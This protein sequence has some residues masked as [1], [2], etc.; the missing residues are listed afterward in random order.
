MK[1]HA[2]TFGADGSLIGIITEGETIPGDRTANKDTAALLFNAGLIH[3]IGPNRVYVKLARKLA[4]L[5]ITVLRFDFSGIGDS[6]PRKD[7]LP[8]GASILDEARQAMD[9]LSQRYGAERFICIGLCAGA[10][11]AAQISVN[12]GRVDK[13]ILINPLLPKTQQTDLMHY[14][15]Y[16]HSTALF[17]PRS[18][19]R[20][21]FLKS[22]YQTLWQVVCLRIRTKFRSNSLS[23]SELP[24]IINE[25]KGFFHK[26]KTRGIRLFLACS[27]DDIGDQYL[28][29]VIGPEYNALKRSGQMTTVSLIGADH[30]LT[31]LVCQQRLLDLVGVW[32]NGA[33]CPESIPTAGVLAV[34]LV[35]AYR[36]TPMEHAAQSAPVNL[37]N[38][39]WPR[40]VSDSMP[41]AIETRDLT[42]YY[43]VMSGWKKLLGKHDSG[44]CAVDHVNLRVGKNEL[45]GLV[46]PN[47]AGKTTLIKMLTTLVLPT[48]GSIQIAGY[49]IR[50]EE[51]VKKA[52]GL[53]TS[54]ERSFYWR[55]TGRQNLQFFASLHNIPAR[56]AESAIRSVLFQVGMEAAADRRFHTYSTGMRQRLAIARALLTEPTVVFM[57][58]PTKGLDPLAA[59]HLHQLIREHL[60]EELGLTVFLTSHQLAEVEKIC[61]RIAVMH[62]GQIRAC[63]TMAELRRMLG[64]VEKYRVRVDRLDS[65]SAVSIGMQD[66]AIRISPEENLLLFEFDKDEADE[67]LMNVISAVQQKRGR[68]KTVSCTPVSL[69]VIFQHLTAENADSSRHD[70]SSGGAAAFSFDAGSP[71]GRISAPAGADPGTGQ[72]CASGLLHW[73]AAKARVAKALL[74]R[75]MLSETSYRFSFF[76]Q[77][78]EIFLTVTALFFLSR[79]VGQDTIARYLRPYGGNYFAFAIIG[80]AFYGYFSVGFSVFADQLREAQMSG[81]LEAML[82]TPAGLSTIVLGSSLWKF[83]MTTLRVVVILLCGALMLG[84][85][86]EGGSWP[87]V[88]LIMAMTVIS[89]CS[90]GTIAACFIIVVKRGDPISWIFKSASWLMG[91][92]V[93]PVTVLPAWMQKLA[94]LLPT[95]HALQAMRLVMLKGKGFVD[96]EPELIALALFCF[97]LLPVSLRTL[98]YAVRRAKREGTLTHF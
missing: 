45:F 4:Q 24:D 17:N 49:N 27:E 52:I 96:I 78:V 65:R 74:R 28:Q 35:V 50:M 62:E 55:L 92:V 94:L 16:Y 68:I 70:P 9:L 60:I 36:K 98:R 73:I 57:D 82:A 63:G 90:F 64:P 21:L 93:F 56:K 38:R 76:M 18:W 39:P 40:T 25:L 23:K 85:G 61:D 86:M 47:G 8:A 80:V 7:K 81:T 48:S 2:L 1:E 46:G 26:I 31:P 15:R 84:G 20:F 3:R 54:D 22:N 30:L 51:K 11:A 13:V 58:E 66:P 5:G 29:S 12:D 43:P 6:G 88:L 53:A 10:A 41:A 14:S 87:L 42:K 71:G 37:E 33:A 83:A 19:L 77:M 97:V 34:N 67:R 79:L 32:L 91:G 75:D 72:G 59:N 89:A 95:T 44:T 69:D